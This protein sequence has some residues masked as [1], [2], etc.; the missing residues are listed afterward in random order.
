ME[1]KTPHLL[2]ELVEKM[3]NEIERLLRRDQ[4]YWDDELDM[5]KNCGTEVQRQ[6]ASSLER[7]KQE[8]DKT[9]AGQL[10]HIRNQRPFPQR[11]LI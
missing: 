5:A 6:L 1:K 10:E 11:P 2:Q 8:L 4:T 3:K 9:L 7:C